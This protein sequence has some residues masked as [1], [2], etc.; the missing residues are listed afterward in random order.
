[1][2]AAEKIMRTLEPGESFHGT[3]SDVTIE[4]AGRTHTVQA[5]I[6]LLGKDLILL[7]G[8][9]MDDVPANHVMQRLLRCACAAAISKHG[10]GEAAFQVLAHELADAFS[11]AAAF[12]DH[13]KSNRKAPS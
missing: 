7:V 12:M 6:G 2:D 10:S 5:C 13:H 1:M 11:H 8:R 9:P 4:F 3:A